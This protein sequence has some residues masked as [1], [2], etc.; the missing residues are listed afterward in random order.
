MNI[1]SDF[2]PPVTPAPDRLAAMSD[3]YRVAC[4]ALV[5]ATDHNASEAQQEA[6]FAI[7]QREAR[8]VEGQA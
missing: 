3:G 8:A 2:A 6:L 4:E 5:L 7:V 1:R